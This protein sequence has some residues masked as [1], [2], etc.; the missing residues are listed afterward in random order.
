LDAHLGYRTAK[1]FQKA[2]TLGVACHV[3]FDT[4]VYEFGVCDIAFGVARTRDPQHERSLLRL[5]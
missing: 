3:Q 5:S 1:H 2:A 4:T